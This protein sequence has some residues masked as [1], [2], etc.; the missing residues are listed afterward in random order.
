M[1]G[2]RTLA[3]YQHNQTLIYPKIHV[4]LL[5]STPPLACADDDNN[6]NYVVLTK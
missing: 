6:N 2:W 1:T 4:L 3:G 5:P